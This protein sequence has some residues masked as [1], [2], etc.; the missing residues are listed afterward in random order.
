MLVLYLKRVALVLIGLLLP[1]LLFEAGHRL[2]GET[3]RVLDYRAERAV[4]AAGRLILCVG[5]SHTYGTSI[6]RDA[7]YP[8]Q[9]ESHLNGIDPD[10]RYTVVNRGIPGLNSAQLASSLPA[11]IRDYRPDLVVVW[12]GTNNWWNREDP[13]RVRNGE[14]GGSL[15]QRVRSWSRLYRVWSA[16]KA[17]RELGEVPAF[18]QEPSADLPM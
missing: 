15:L 11:W 16:G 17:S 10:G 14:G 13:A 2:V 7:A 12:I 8:A 5:D 18:A 3:L 4:D 1:I 6:P 9:L